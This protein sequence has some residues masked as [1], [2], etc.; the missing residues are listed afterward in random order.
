MPASLDRMNEMSPPA[1][2]ARRE[3]PRRQH[4]A[5]AWVGA[6]VLG[7]LTV[8][9]LA[10]PALFV[11]LLVGHTSMDWQANHASHLMA[12]RTALLIVLV[13]VCG[14]AVC[15]LATMLLGR[16]ASVAGRARTMAGGAFLASLMLTIGGFF[17]MIGHA[18]FTF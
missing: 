3:A 2:A 5:A 10:P 17:W 4:D 14:A 16:R 7:A 1:L 12:A 11:W 6:F 18:Q 13:P 8:V 15:G 9:A